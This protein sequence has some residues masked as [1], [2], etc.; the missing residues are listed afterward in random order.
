MSA[1]SLGSRAYAL[2]SEAASPSAASSHDT[3]CHETSPQATSPQEMSSQETSSQATSCQDTSPQATSPQATESQETSAL[4]ASDQPTESKT[5]TLA[6]V[7]SGPTNLS[8]PAFGFGGL[9]SFEAAK[10]SSSPRPT[11]PG[12]AFGVFFADAISAPFTWSGVNVGCIARICAAAPA[13]AGAA[14]EVPDSWM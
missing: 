5:G 4:A 13:T 2:E 1:M 10:A 11:E 6:P 7:G 9:F 14:N 8:R 3:S 12:A